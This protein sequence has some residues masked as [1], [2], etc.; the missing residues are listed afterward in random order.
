MPFELLVGFKVCKLSAQF[1]LPPKA[2]NY[3]HETKKALV[4]KIRCSYS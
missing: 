1:Y 3:Y 4:L 2:D